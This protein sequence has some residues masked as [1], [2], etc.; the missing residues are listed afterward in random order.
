[1]T[2]QIAQFFADLDRRGPDLLPDKYTGTIRLD[3]AD[4]HNV[5]QWVLV[6]DRGKVSVR[7][8]G[9]EPDCLIRA[10]QELFARVLAGSPGIYAAVWSNR[11][12]VEGDFTMLALFRELLARV[13]GDHCDERKAEG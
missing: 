10:R 6:I 4:D 12:S 8:D 2:E 3:L 5:D 7:R 11:I 13:A 9:G 1:V